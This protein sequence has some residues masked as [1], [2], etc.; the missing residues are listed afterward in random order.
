MDDLGGGNAE[1]FY[2]LRD[3]IDRVVNTVNILKKRDPSR[4]ESFVKSNREVLAARDYAREVG[5]VLSRIRDRRSLVI[6]SSMSSPE[7][8]RILRELKR[9]EIQVMSK[10]PEL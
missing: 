8:G 9:I 1:D 2:R 7:K 4:V 3:E 10:P 5:K 6:G